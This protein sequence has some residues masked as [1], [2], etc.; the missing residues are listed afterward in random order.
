MFL[1]RPKS[2][3]FTLKPWGESGEDASST[4]PARIKIKIKFHSQSQSQTLNLEGDCFAGQVQGCL[5]FDE[6]I[7][8]DSSADS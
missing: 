2:E 4:L 1:D 8:Q 5:I 6:T 7:L 3:I